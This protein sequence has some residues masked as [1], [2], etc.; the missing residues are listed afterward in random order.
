MQEYY[1]AIHTLHNTIQHTWVPYK[2]KTSI[3]EPH[4]PSQCAAKAMG[5]AK[6]HNSLEQNSVPWFST[7]YTAD[8]GGYITGTPFA[9]CTVSSMLF[10]TGGKAAD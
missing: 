1:L 10:I 3:P 8:V 4:N 5:H 6:A 7:G 2:T 9:W